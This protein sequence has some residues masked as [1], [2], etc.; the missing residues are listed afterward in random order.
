[1]SQSLMTKSSLTGILRSV[2]FMLAMRSTW[3]RSELHHSWWTASTSVSNPNQLTPKPAVITGSSKREKNFIIYLGGSIFW[4]G[5]GLT[6]RWYVPFACCMAALRFRPCSD[7]V[8]MTWARQLSKWAFLLLG[9]L[10]FSIL[11]INCHTKNLL[12]FPSFAP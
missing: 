9:L 10:G 6:G 1:V 5:A 2:T 8:F 11:I 7:L 12:L 3:F 4:T